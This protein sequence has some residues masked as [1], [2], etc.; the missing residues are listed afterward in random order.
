MRAWPDRRGAIASRGGADGRRSASSALRA[1]S[2]GSGSRRTAPPT[3]S[4]TRP[5]SSGTRWA[6]CRPR[7]LGPGRTPGLA[8]LRDGSSGQPEVVDHPPMALDRAGRGEVLDPHLLRALELEQ[9]VVV[10]VGMGRRDGAAGSEE[11]G[12]IDLLH[13]GP[14]ARHDGTELG[15]RPPERGDVVEVVEADAQVTGGDLR[16]HGPDVIG[17]RGGRAEACVG[18]RHRCRARLDPGAG[19]RRPGSADPPGR[20]RP[21]RGRGGSGTSPRPRQGWLRETTGRSCGS[22]D[23]ARTLPAAQSGGNVPE[24]C[25]S[26]GSQTSPSTY[27]PTSAGPAVLCAPRSEATSQDRRATYRTLRR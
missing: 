7:R 21:R 13:V 26:S 23:Q 20:P 22:S 6:G 27:V 17:L 19:A 18:G 10:P 16:D 5:A 14:R 1:G 25:R 12:Q 9:Q 8:E 15:G 3:R 4:R 2:P 24:P 11:Q